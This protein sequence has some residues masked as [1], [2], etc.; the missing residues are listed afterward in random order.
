MNMYK[1]NSRAYDLAI[2]SAGGLNEKMAFGQRPF[3]NLSGGRPC[4]QRG[5]PVKK[6]HAVCPHGYKARK[7][8]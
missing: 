6:A 3:I 8:R 5:Q 4:R 7:G 1:H 2:L